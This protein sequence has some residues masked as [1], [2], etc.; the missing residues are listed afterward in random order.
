MRMRGLVPFVCCL[1]ACTGTVGESEPVGG[2]AATDT[3][4]GSETDPG[5]DSGSSPDT[6]TPPEDTAPPPPPPDTAPP[7]PPPDTGDPL[8]D[9]RVVCVNEINMYRATLSLPPYSGWTAAETC[10]D[11]QSKS[12]SETG[13]AHG[14]F[15]KCGESA[16]NECPGWPGPP[17][18][19][20]KGCLKMMWAEGPGVPFSAHGHYINMSST[21]Y[22]SVACGF[23]KTPTGSWWAVQDFR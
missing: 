10:A 20:I 8:A 9:A 12:D 16:Q 18:T 19:M 5:T 17:D 7:P 1:L 22:K 3:Q 2:D 11:G 14:A 21:S 4:G 15:G 13:T 23:Y 6:S